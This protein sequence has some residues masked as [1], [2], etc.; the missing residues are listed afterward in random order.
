MTTVESPFLLDEYELYTYQYYY[1]II[2]IDDIH[3]KNS[4]DFGKWLIKFIINFINVEKI[5]KYFSDIL[6]HIILDDNINFEKQDIELLKNITILIK[7]DDY[8]SI[9]GLKYKLRDLLTLPNQSR[10]WSLEYE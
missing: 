3:F 7:K 2:S 6:V 1:D 8:E 4:S 9:N 10:I 5:D